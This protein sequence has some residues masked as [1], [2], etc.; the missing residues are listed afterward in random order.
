MILLK[1]VHEDICTTQDVNA[2]FIL[3]S[4][5]TAEGMSKL[6]DLIRYSK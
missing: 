1:S 3:K 4:E 6:I 5:K 2:R